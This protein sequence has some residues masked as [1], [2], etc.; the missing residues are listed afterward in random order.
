MIKEE[1][2]V[3]EMSAET[4]DC[5][6][7]AVSDAY[8]KTADVRVY[9]CEKILEI[10]GNLTAEDYQIRY[11]SGKFNDFECA[12]WQYR[13]TEETAKSISAI[14]ENV[15][16]LQECVTLLE[17]PELVYFLFRSLSDILNSKKCMDTLSHKVDL[18]QSLCMRQ[19]AV[20]ANETILSIIS[21]NL[22]ELPLIKFG[23]DDVC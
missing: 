11:H 4:V 3:V 5:I 12:Y 13:N 6:R 1:K 10:G 19:Y 14:L 17:R 7:K 2:M 15:T 23:G 8:T 9:I 18:A 20:R 22:D 16:K 21:G